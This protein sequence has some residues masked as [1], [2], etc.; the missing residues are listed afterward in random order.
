MSPAR[1][2]VG[3]F[4]LLAALEPKTCQTGLILLDL[5]PDLGSRRPE[6]LL[7]TI[8]PH[9]FAELSG[10][11]RTSHAIVSGFAGTVWITYT[12]SLGLY[13]AK[14]PTTV[15]S[16]HP[17]SMQEASILLLRDPYSSWLIRRGIKRES[18]Q[19]PAAG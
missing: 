1:S 16:L 4:Y 7:T 17:V 15:R 9:N 2:T 13:S 14:S 19:G 11:G 3:A 18:T 8:S 6:R 5:A 12:P 10:R